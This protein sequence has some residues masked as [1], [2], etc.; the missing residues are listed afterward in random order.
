MVLLDPEALEA[1]RQA[2][3]T[4]NL[5]VDEYRAKLAAQGL[6]GRYIGRNA[7]HHAAALDARAGLSAIME[8]WGGARKADGLTDREM[9]RLFYERFGVDVLSA[10]GLPREDTVKLVDRIALDVAVKLR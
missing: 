4:A 10:Q 1:L 3:D 5:S 6:P 7:K 2:V 8:M 9:Q